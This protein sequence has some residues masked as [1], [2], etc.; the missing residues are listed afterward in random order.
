MLV[1]WRNQTKRNIYAAKRRL[2]FHNFPLYFPESNGSLEHLVLDHLA[3]A[4]VLIFIKN[5]SSTL[6]RQAL[7]FSNWLMN[8]LTFS[9]IDDKYHSWNRKRILLQTFT[10]FPNS[11]NTDFLSKTARERLYWRI[12][13]HFQ[14]LH[15]CDFTELKGENLPELSTL[16]DGL[17]RQSSI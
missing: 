12:F 10:A 15:N 16:L 3:R 17:L 2:H 13:Y 6:W 5:L 8:L 1:K 7:A 4:I 9:I 14:R 11:L